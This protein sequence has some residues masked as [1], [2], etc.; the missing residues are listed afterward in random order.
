MDHQRDINELERRMKKEKDRR[1]FERYQAVYLYTQG[2]TRKEIV[3]IIGR[4]E[5]TVS[6]YIRAFQDGGVDGLQMNHSPGAS[7]RLTPLPQ[8]G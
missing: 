5:K 3:A 6:K 8:S 1:M 4:N 7:R 2:K